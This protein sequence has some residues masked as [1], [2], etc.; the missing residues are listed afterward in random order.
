MYCRE[1]LY[2]KKARKNGAS[3]YWKSSGG[4]PTGA[5]PPCARMLWGK[6]AGSH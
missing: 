4:K 6:R 5:N 3:G 2:P 1:E